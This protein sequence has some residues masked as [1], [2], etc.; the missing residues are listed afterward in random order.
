MR[1]VVAFITLAL[2]GSCGTEMPPQQTA[3]AGSLTMKMEETQ[4][5]GKP[6]A[7]LMLCEK[8]TCMNPLRDRSGESFYF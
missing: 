1:I 2:L 7:V 4:V 5:D 3:T 8:E 6:A